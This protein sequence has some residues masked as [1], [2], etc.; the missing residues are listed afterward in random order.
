MYNKD[1][2]VK[3]NQMKAAIMKMFAL[4]SWE[5]FTFCAQTSEI[6]AIYT[7][8]ECKALKK[9]A[10]ILCDKLLQDIFGDL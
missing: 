6:D 2:K 10:E 9:H 4:A 7:D 1:G 5:I 3:R 8:K